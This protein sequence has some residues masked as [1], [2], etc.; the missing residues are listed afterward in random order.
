MPTRG[1]DAEVP[2]DRPEVQRARAAKDRAARRLRRY[3]NVIGTGVGY[4]I[5]RG[6]RTGTVCIRV[7]V[8]K[9]V[10]ERGLSPSDVVPKE[11][12]GVATDVIEDRFR[13]HQ[14]PPVS[15]HRRRRAFL[16]GGISVGNL[17][18]GGSGTLGACVF[19][20]K[21]GHQLMLSNWHVLCG[22]AECT[23]GERIIQPGTG[24]D[25]TGTTGDVVARL[26]RFSLT[27]VVDAAVARVTGHRMLF[28]E[29]LGIGRPRGSA[30][31]VLGEGVQKSG[32]TTGITPGVV[33]DIDADFDVDYSDLGM[34][35]RHFEQQIVI[36]GDGISL[37]GDSGSV[38][39]NS[40][41]EV[42]G[43]NFAGNEAGTR[44]DANPIDAVIEE[45]GFVITP[46]MPLQ[47][48][49]LVSAGLS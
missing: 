24:G 27:G 5:I 20:A 38:W 18:L 12:D 1:S 41:N 34:G 21:T 9:K 14:A 45:L 19:D 49:L 29:I 44:A 37:P 6:E 33:A 7:Y 40:R 25:D 35:D 4:K 39:L 43:L 28:E 17:I 3:P 36:E 23:E 30:T 42:I 46:G 32:R 16:R 15:E 22:R 10:P 31:A 8:N 13:I 47:D 11:I 48:H 26:W 2:Q